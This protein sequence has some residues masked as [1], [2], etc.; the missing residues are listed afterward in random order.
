MISINLIG[1]GIVGKTIGKLATLH[2]TA[3]IN[4]VFN[5][6][7][8]DALLSTHFIGQ[9]EAIDDIR[10]L[11]PA[12]IHFI[13]TPDHMIESMCQLICEHHIHPGSIVLHCSGTIPVSALTAAKQKGCFI[14]RVHPIK[15]MYSKE[16]G[17]QVFPDTSCI[18]EGDEEAYSSL[19]HFFS[20]I[21]GKV[22]KINEQKDGKYH[23]A[24][25]FS[26]SY[27]QILLSVSSILYQQCGMSKETATQLSLNIA[28]QALENREPHQPYS[29]YVEGPV[30][31]LDTL[32][33][34]KNVSS[35]EN[36]PAFKQLYAALASIALS[37]TTHSHDE[38]KRV[39]DILDSSNP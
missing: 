33:I 2:R 7:M 28:R 31:R 6:R 12:D 13:L 21:K 35:L 39:L 27:H 34:Q 32:T 17:V 23:T 24:C 38:K 10:L 36:Q 29:S 16:H 11:S 19:Q 25:V 18:F 3:K 22:I 9:G 30:K 8:E 37:L 20:A 5:R 1:A 26:A 4:S 14:A 15:H